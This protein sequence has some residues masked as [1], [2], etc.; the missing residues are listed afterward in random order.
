MYKSII[1][2]ASVNELPTISVRAPP[3]EAFEMCGTFS[4]MLFY[5]LYGATPQS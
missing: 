2:N 3:F 1:I 4:S 5:Y